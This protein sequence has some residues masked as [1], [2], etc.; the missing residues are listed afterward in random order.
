MSCMRAR[1]RF[2]RASATIAP[3][4]MIMPSHREASEKQPVAS[5]PTHPA[6]QSAGDGRGGPGVGGGS[7]SAVAR[8]LSRVQRAGWPVRH[9]SARNRA[10]GT[11]AIG[12][13]VPGVDPLRPSRVADHLTAESSLPAM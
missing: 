10:P 1:R 4:H 8:H 5:D 6:A 2:L 3:R 11:L 12:P 7:P 13:D 9:C